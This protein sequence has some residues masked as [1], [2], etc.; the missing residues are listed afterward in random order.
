[1]ANN[2][3]ARVVEGSQA[4]RDR[5]GI[6]LNPGQ[7]RD[8]AYVFRRIFEA[9]RALRVHVDLS[10]KTDREMA[11]AFDRFV[12]LVRGNVW[13][14]ATILKEDRQEHAVIF[15]NGTLVRFWKDR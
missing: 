5:R 13:T 6:R 11:T 14:G 15:S 7:P 2:N 10:D 1:M 8:P 12:E 4:F 3:A 9:D